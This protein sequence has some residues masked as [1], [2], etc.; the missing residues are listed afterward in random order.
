MELLN[1]KKFSHYCGNGSYFECERCDFTKPIVAKVPEKLTEE[2]FAT[3]VAEM[4]G[5]H[6]QAIWENLN[7]FQGYNTIRFRVTRE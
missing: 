3:D 7:G 1:N 2:Q 4:I 6:A 5:Y